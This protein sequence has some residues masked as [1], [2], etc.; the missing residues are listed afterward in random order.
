MNLL[1]AIFLA[2]FQLVAASGAAGSSH[3]AFLQRL[4][5]AALERTHHTVRYDVAYVRIPYPNGDVPADTGVCTDEVIRV[6]R[7]Q[8]IDLQKEVHEDL[9]ADFAAYPNQRRWLLAH[10]D[11]NIDHR[12][13][14][15]LM[16]FFSRK[17]QSLHGGAQ[18]R[19][20]PAHGRCLI[21]VAR[22]GALS[23]FRAF[24]V[25]YESS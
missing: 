13:V 1:P 10:A 4:S 9:L 7:T 3:T 24:A 19:A 6:Y 12:R 15:K 14:P 21:F 17:G 2:Y 20:G 18:Y 16:V 23:L 22:D 11:S 25:I 5:S 8:G